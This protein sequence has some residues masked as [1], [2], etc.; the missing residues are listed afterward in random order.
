[1]SLGHNLLQVSGE[2]DESIQPVVTNKGNILVYNGEIYGIDVFDTKYLCD[3]LDFYGI[4]FLKKVNGH[5]ALAWYEP[6]KDR[7]SLVRDHFG[8]KPLYFSMN[9]GG[10]CFSSSLHSINTQMHF[11]VDPEIRH[12]SNK[13]DRFYPG[14][15]CLYKGVSKLFPG[16]Y[17]TYDVKRSRVISRGNIHDYQLGDSN[18]TDEEAKELISNSIQSVAKNDHKTAILLSGGLDST[19][20]LSETLKVTDNV[21]TTTCR[22]KPSKSEETIERYIDDAERA[23]KTSMM[24]GVNNHHVTVDQKMFYQDFHNFLKPLHTATWDYFRISPRYYA[25]R[26]AHRQGAK[27]ILSGDGAD[28]LFTG[29]T[30]DDRYYYPDLIEQTKEFLDKDLKENFPWFPTH[31]FGDDVINNDRMKWL[32]LRDEFAIVNDAYAGYFGMETRLPYFHQELVI[33]MLSIPGHLKLRQTSQNI[34]KG[35]RKYY[36]RELF[37]DELPEFITKTNRK[38][39]CAMPWNSRNDGRNRSIYYQMVD[40]MEKIINK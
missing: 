29:Y 12:E 4:D 31:I 20:V 28:E 22:F 35:F 32:L 27:I 1:V 8:T 26:E 21:I 39:G 16:E 11:E 37:K 15:R 24:Y 6:S 14:N 25:I 7:L 38:T 9:D 17:I 3:M 5:F 23:E 2:L 40:T 30:G 33:K 19:L 18:M 13:I 10:I 36:I 34:D